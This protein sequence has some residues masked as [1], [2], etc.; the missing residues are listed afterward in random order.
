MKGSHKIVN[1]IHKI[2]MAKY[3]DLKKCKQ[4]VKKSTSSIIKNARFHQ[5]HLTL[6]KNQY[7]LYSTKL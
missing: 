5:S 6:L 4:Y 2:N 3:Y 1:M 7:P